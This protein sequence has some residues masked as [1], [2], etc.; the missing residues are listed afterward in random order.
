M[1]KD[2]AYYEEQLKKYQ[3]ELLCTYNRLTEKINHLA[4]CENL[5][6]FYIAYADEISWESGDNYINTRYEIA[7]LESTID[8]ILAEMQYIADKFITTGS[9]AKEYAEYLPRTHIDIDEQIPF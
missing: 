9:R 6:E 3:E 1:E 8:A 5:Y 7:E 2:E 4:T